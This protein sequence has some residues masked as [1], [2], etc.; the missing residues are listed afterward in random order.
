MGVFSVFFTVLRFGFDFAL[1]AVDQF[2]SG[3]QLWCVLLEPFTGYI[4]DVVYVPHA[5][6]V[7][8]IAGDILHSSVK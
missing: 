7:V 6:V 4:I 1:H 3:K 5:E 2:A 8:L